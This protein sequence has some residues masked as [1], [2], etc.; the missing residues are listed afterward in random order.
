MSTYINP[1]L[2]VDV[3][4]FTVI[5][6]IP[7]VAIHN[8]EFAPE[9]DKLALPGVLMDEVDHKG[10]T[11]LQACDR[12]LQKVDVSNINMISSLGYCDNPSRDDRFRVIS[13]PHIATTSTSDGDNDNTQWMRVDDD[14]TDLAFDHAT[15][16][17]EAKLAL[18]NA[19]T[20]DTKLFAGMFGTTMTAPGVK[21]ALSLLAPEKPTGAV[22]RD[23]K[24]HYVQTHRMTVPGVEGGRPSSV[25][26]AM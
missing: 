18:A 11:I 15:I 24:K 13:L 4:C 14:F 21:K 8:R 10:E 6:N 12:A 9:Q 3:V 25:F 2:G 5:D 19:F 1:A 17:A 26:V 23:L 7:Y 20:D 22:L 16:I